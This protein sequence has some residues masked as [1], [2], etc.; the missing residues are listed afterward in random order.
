MTA[1]TLIQTR[2]A[3]FRFASIADADSFQS[4]IWNDFD[5]L[6]TCQVSIGPDSCNRPTRTSPIERL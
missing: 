1:L 6:M 3:L 4:F 5:G 2:E